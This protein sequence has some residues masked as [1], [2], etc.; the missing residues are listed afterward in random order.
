MMQDHEELLRVYNFLEHFQ[1]LGLEI[2]TYRLILNFETES[3]Y[4]KHFT[5]ENLYSSVMFSF[6]DLKGCELYIDIKGGK[7][8]RYM[9]SIWQ[10]VRSTKEPV[11]FPK[12]FEHFNDFYGPYTPYASG[13]VW[14]RNTLSTVLNFLLELKRLK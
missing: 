13:F 1:E 3:E 11:I 4:A 5:I 14:P 6:S 7:I 8:F 2:E 10:E 9:C 12:E